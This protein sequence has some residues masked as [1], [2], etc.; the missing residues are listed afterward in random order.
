MK[1]SVTKTNKDTALPVSVKPDIV[2]VYAEDILNMPE[3]DNKGI[4]A[5]TEIILKPIKSP[6]SL[7]LTS[8][9]QIAN[10]NIEGETETRGWI[11]KISGTFPGTG[12][13]IAE[14]VSANIN[15]GFVAFRKQCSGIY[16]I[17]GSKYNPLFFTGNFLE[18]KDKA[19]CQIEFLQT[20]KSKVPYIFYD[21]ADVN[22]MKPGENRKW[23]LSDGSGN[24]FIFSEDIAIEINIL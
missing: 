24:P 13:N 7:Y 8:S 4:K 12:L 23:V 9:E 22:P 14:W 10:S 16:K 15:Q 21:I 1:F 5:V 11:H 18:D 19:V 2:L 3:T 17:Y 20:R 6:Y